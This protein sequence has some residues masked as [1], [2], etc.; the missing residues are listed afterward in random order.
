[1]QISVTLQHQVPQS[2]TELRAL[3]CAAQA[4]E[5]HAG[6]TRGSMQLHG[7]AVG[8]RDE[9]AIKTLSSIRAML[10]HAE[11]SHTPSKECFRGLWPGSEV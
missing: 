5:G 7:W 6:E 8:G 2:G 10:G 1:M 9:G 3:T 11:R 4:L